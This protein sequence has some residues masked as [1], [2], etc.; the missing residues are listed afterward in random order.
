MASQGKKPDKSGRLPNLPAGKSKSKKRFT[1]PYCDQIIND[2]KE[3]LI[4]CDGQC[5]TWLHQRC[6]GLTK[7]NLG[8]LED[9]DDKFYCLVCTVAIQ[10][11][12]I[13]DLKE[14]VSNLSANL[15]SIENRFTRHDS[16]NY[17]LFSDVAGSKPPDDNSAS[18]NVSK[19]LSQYRSAHI[20]T[21][22]TV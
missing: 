10:R 20:H 11:Q 6:A 16:V 15:I 14:M 17:C 21:L 1:C 5:A 9:S 12:E 4:Y 7:A 13:A 19:P 8:R 22:L 3:D 2:A 18:C